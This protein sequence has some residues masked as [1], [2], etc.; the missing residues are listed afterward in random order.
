MFSAGAMGGALV[1][2][3]LAGVTLAGQDTPPPNSA[4]LERALE[5]PRNALELR[6]RLGNL[7]AAELPGLLR[8]AAEGRL[9]GDREVRLDDEER[10]LVRESL[11]ARPRRE[12]VPF[13]TD[14]AAAQL[15]PPL[16]LEAQRLL[17]SMG[18]GD[19]IRLLARLTHPPREAGPIATE[20]RDGFR[21]AL[22]AI[23]ARDPAALAEVPLFFS[24]SSA[25]LS[26][27]IIEAVAEL[28]TPEATRLLASLL[29]RTPG[30]D[31]LLLARLAE[32]SSL[33]PGSDEFVL[34]TVRRYLGQRD[35]ALVCA[36]ALACGKLGDD[37]A[38][39]ALIGLIDHPEERVR[40]GA[41]LSLASLSGLAY[42]DEAARWTSWY[43]AEMRWWDEEA[44]SLLVRVER[45]RGLEFVRAAREVLEHR[46]FRDRMAESF[47]LAL[48][49]ESVEEVR[50]ACRALEQLR[51]P[52]GVRA[53]VECLERNEPAVRQAA[54]KALRAITGVELPPESD[55][56]AALTQ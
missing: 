25:F 52:V 41:F 27:S 32:R 51:S 45:G 30:L 33:R 22:A 43:H 40:H 48:R 54:W 8:L 5:E 11:A 55:S 28:R 56:W 2:A 13:L 19:H 6:R 15:T 4:R 36:A 3:L 7:D 35:P 18:A 12:L 38:V 16:R 37:S 14:I 47:A 34:E 26:S 42:G 1:L 53:L 49:R 24:E 31:P 46:L 23:L 39:E 44:E 50:L 10:Q 17:G 9:Q 21:S 20:L 29:G